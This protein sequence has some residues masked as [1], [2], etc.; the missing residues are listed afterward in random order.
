MIGERLLLVPA[1]RALVL[2]KYS[3]FNGTVDSGI[4]YL[5]LCRF[6]LKPVGYLLWRP[7]VFLNEAADIFPLLRLA[8]DMLSAAGFSPFFIALLC[9]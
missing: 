1:G 5:H 7:V 4:A 8:E 6:K 2:I 3:G 9:L